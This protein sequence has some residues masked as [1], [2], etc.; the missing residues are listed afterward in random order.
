MSI[1]LGTAWSSTPTSTQSYRS[2]IAFQLV[3]YLVVSFV[4]L[5]FVSV[6]VSVRREQLVFAY[7]S[8]KRLKCHIQWRFNGID[9]CP[10]RR[11]YAIEQLCVCVCPLSP[12]PF[13]VCLN[14]C[15][16][17][18][19]KSKPLDVLVQI[20]IYSLAAKKG[21]EKRINKTKKR[22]TMWHGV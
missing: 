2:L 18:L 8:F 3:V 22:E 20:K 7:E 14:D 9:K 1:I 21:E 4:N 5:V 15:K 6:D 11:L 12:P 17:H 13:I 10:K 19:V 16:L